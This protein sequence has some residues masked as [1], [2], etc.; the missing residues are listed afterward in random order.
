MGRVGALGISVPNREG[1][2]GEIEAKVVNLGAI[3]A[4]RCPFEYEPLG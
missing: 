1:K 3:Q 4:E 2:L